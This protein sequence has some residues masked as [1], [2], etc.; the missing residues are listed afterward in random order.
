MVA[1]LGGGLAGLTL[2]A[3]GSG[4]SVV[5][6]PILVLG[7]G[8]DA[9]EA[10]GTALMV[11]LAT[12]LVGGLLHGRAG[13]VRVSDAALFGVPGVLAAAAASPLN[14]YL[15]EEL[16]LG[17]IAVLMLAV[18]L[19]IWQPLQPRTGRRPVPVVIAVGAAVG[20]LTGIFGVGGGFVIVPALVLALGLPMHAAVG[21]SLLVI[22]ANALAALG[23]YW[24]R[25]DIDIGLALVLG[26]GAALGVVSGSTLSRIAGERRLQQ[27]FAV[28]LVVFAVY[29]SARE[30]AFIA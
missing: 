25:G 27:A 1:L 24:L 15:S 26:T 13:T 9:H 29:L 8:L 21:T 18:A 16:L 7:L 23:G 5:L 28:L 17:G 2:G 22:A 3:L 30:V 4:G 10:T 6:I 14:S 20:A 11:V 12:S 19:R